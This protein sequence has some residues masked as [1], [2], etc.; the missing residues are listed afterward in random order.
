MRPRDRGKFFLR[1]NVG[2]LLRADSAGRA[3]FYSTT[4]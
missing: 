4:L 1:F 3:A 2:D